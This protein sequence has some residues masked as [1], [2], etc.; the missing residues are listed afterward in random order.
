MKLF[1]LV[2]QARRKNADL[3]EGIPNPRAAAIVR[4]VFDELLSE[5][6]AAPEGEVKLPVL[7]VFV[8]KHI[9]YTKDGNL[10][11]WRRI[12]FQPRKAGK[13]GVKPTSQKDAVDPDAND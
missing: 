13:K 3:F 9:E 11:L 10:R 8:I 7:G 4:S 1:D 12:I 6:D 2:N 5:L